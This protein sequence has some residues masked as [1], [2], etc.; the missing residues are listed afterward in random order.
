LP[1]ERVTDY[2][3][4]RMDETLPPAPEGAQ[5]EPESEAPVSV[6]TEEEAPPAPEELEPDPEPQPTAEELAALQERL[7]RAERRADELAALSRR[8]ADMADELHKDNQRLREGEMALALAPMI[9][10]LA[11]VTDDLDRIRSSRPDDEDLAHLDSRMREVLHDLGATTV[12]PPAGD[13]FDAR[14]HQAVGSMLTEDQTLDR[15]VAE[16]RRDGLVVEG[17]RVLRAADVVVFRYQ[18]PPGPEPDN[19]PTSPEAGTDT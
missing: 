2:V 8:Q 4:R 12:R 14:A 11:R 13:P 1:N 16:V 15:C 5:D 3:S 9:R 17:G 18:A 19:P 10:G 7:E 6:V